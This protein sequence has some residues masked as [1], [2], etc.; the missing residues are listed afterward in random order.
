M[1]QDLEPLAQGACTV[2]NILINPCQRAPAAFPGFLLFT[3]GAVGARTSFDFSE[4][5]WP[6]LNTD[7]QWNPKQRKI[8]PQCRHA[9]SFESFLGIL[10]LDPRLFSESSINLFNMFVDEFDTLKIPVHRF[11]TR[12]TLKTVIC[13]SILQA[14][15]LAMRF[16]N[17]FERT[18]LM[19]SLI[20]NL[21]LAI[22]YWHSLSCEVIDNPR[23]T[24]ILLTAIIFLCALPGRLQSCV[25]FSKFS[26]RF[27]MFKF[28]HANHFIPFVF[29]SLLRPWYHPSWKLDFNR[30]MIYQSLLLEFSSE[31]GHSY[32]SEPFV[33]ETLVGTRTLHPVVCTCKL[34]NAP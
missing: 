29:E 22:F 27:S 4:S 13:L 24:S 2:L 21:P 1:Q 10:P 9:H 14:L 19:T 15:F 30:P 28:V 26:P 6:A 5:G 25:Y 12:K 23:V 32:C 17:E 20:I 34:H 18:V 3:F 16:S 31:S 11:G 33:F 8:S 7:R